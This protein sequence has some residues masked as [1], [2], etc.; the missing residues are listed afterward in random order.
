[1]DQIS[2]LELRN[3]LGDTIT[4]VSHTN[5]RI[6]ITKNG[7]SIG[8]LISIDDLALLE[9]LEDER[10]AREAMKLL[11]T[12][13]TTIPFAEFVEALEADIESENADDN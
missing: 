8:A 7:K 11:A 3:S 1:M 10:D 2:L 5:E 9:D 4:R 6:I 13:K 12:T